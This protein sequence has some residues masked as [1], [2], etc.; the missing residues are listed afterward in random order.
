VSSKD[1][2]LLLMFNE[3]IGGFPP[4]PAGLGWAEALRWWARTLNERALRSPWVVNV[5][6][7]GLNTPHQLDLLESGLQLLDE[8]GLP[9]DD[10][11]NLLLV[12]SGMVF[13]HVRM[14]ADF[15][16]TQADGSFGRLLFAAD[17]ADRYPA[18]AALVGSGVFGSAD[19]P[20]DDEDPHDDFDLGLDLL[21]DGLAARLARDDS[22]E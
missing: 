21:I 3:A 2:L 18:I 9:L 15:R 11:A 12:L 17:V 10:R 1:E 16:A 14:V 5:N 22:P 8:T 20:P 13:A 19:D 6:P 4:V 7:T